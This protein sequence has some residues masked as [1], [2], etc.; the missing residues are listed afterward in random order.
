M[1]SIIVQAAACSSKSLSL[2]SSEPSTIDLISL[3]RDNE[4]ENTG[5]YTPDSNSDFSDIKLENNDNDTYIPPGSPYSNSFGKWTEEEISILKRQLHTDLTLDVLK[6]NLPGK[7]LT[8]ITKMVRKLQSQPLWTKKEIDLLVHILLTSPKP[9]IK[10][11]RHNFPC[12]SVASLSKKFQ[13]YKNLSGK[14][15]AL[16]N[17]NRWTVP[18]IAAILSLIQYDLTRDRLNKELPNKTIG[19]IKGLTDNM[20]VNSSFSRIESALLEQELAQNQPIELILDQFPLKDREVFKKELLRLHEVPRFKEMIEKRLGELNSIS[21][22]EL[23]LVRDSIDLD[24]LKYLISNDL[25]RKQLLSLFPGTSIKHLKSIACEIGFDEGNDYTLPEL[26]SLKNALTENIQLKSIVEELPFRSQLSIEKKINEIDPDRRRSVFT[27]KVDELV[28]LAN[29]YSSDTFGNGIG[30]RRPRK[31]IQDQIKQHESHEVDAK[32][33]ELLAG[34]S[35]ICP[36]QKQTSILNQSVGVQNIKKS[37]KLSIVDVLREEATYFQTVTGDGHLIKDGE[38]RMRQRRSPTK[39]ELNSKG[40]KK[41]K[42]NEVTIKENKTSQNNKAIIST[43]IS[44][45]KAKERI[46]D[47]VAAN[48]T[49]NTVIAAKPIETEFDHKRSPFDPESIINDTLIPLNGRRLY[50]NEVY[51][52]QPCFRELS[53][54][55]DSAIMIQEGGDISLSDSIAA[56]IV[57][58]HFK[59]YRD[60]PISFPPL[61]IMDRNTNKTIPNPMNKIRVR[62]LIY[63]Q[64]SEMFVLAEPKSNELDP[65]YEIKKLFQL[66]YALFFSHSLRIKKIILEEYINE[67]D[68][69]IEEND[70]NRFMFVID[71]W[72]CLMVELSPNKIDS[73]CHDI[74]EEIRAFFLPHEIKFP[75][76]EDIRLDLFYSEILQS[77]DE[78]IFSYDDSIEPSSPTFALVESSMT[79]KPDLRSHL[80]PPMSSEEEN[81]PHIEKILRNNLRQET[82]SYTPMKSNRA[83]K[84]FV[85]ALKPEN[86]NEEFFCRLKEKTTISR[87]CLQQ[88]LLRIYSRIVSIE[89]KKLRSYKAF[90]AEVYGELLPSFTSEVLSKVNLQP[91]QKFYDLGSGVGNTTFQAALEFGVVSSGGC[92]IMEHASKLTELQTILIQKHLSLFG[93]KELNLNFALLQ[94]FVDNEEVRNAVL[95]C[96]VLLVNNYLFDVNL[97]ATVGRMLFGLKAGAKIISLRNFIRPRYKASN[98]KTIF[99]FLKVEKSEMSNYLSVSWTA[100][101]LP[102]YISTVQETICEEYL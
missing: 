13:H 40:H 97:N 28:Y 1:K 86:Y 37:K 5:I 98:D 50:V 2:E 69:S 4:M 35:R 64:H 89:S 79:L 94:S 6:L 39:P 102:Y 26:K 73:S 51:G 74:N 67:I 46:N 18:E 30:K 96:D 81:E 27:N 9:S 3:R 52:P 88:I 58:S 16:V 24:R 41:L 31:R 33:G 7:T 91:H 62:F 77:N 20:K 54:V 43:K 32:A 100:N 99:D 55:D 19:E 44:E 83:N 23:K 75:T 57:Y 29:W 14:L 95:D 10:E 11:H 71:K 72:N 93:L 21:Q 17:N 34:Q 8:Q 59:N 65:I 47:K 84:R 92:E 80:T 66:H 22:N 70:F 63:P 56:E 76:D 90:T 12:R 42:L 101:K 85:N 36:N 48:A 78:P 68:V 49:S 38:K 82:G 15:H 87:F 53:F 45:K 61:T 60:M 25:T